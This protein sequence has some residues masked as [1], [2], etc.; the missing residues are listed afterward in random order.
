MLQKI[1]EDI[2]EFDGLIS[3]NTIERFIDEF[4]LPEHYSIKKMIN[5]GNG[6][7]YTGINLLIYKKS[8]LVG[9]VCVDSDKRITKTEY[10]D[11]GINIYKYTNICIVPTKDYREDDRNTLAKE[12]G[13]DY[14]NKLTVTQKI[15]LLQKYVDEHPFVVKPKQTK[16]KELKENDGRRKFNGV[17]G[18]AYVKHKEYVD[19][20]KHLPLNE[21]EAL[22]KEYISKNKNT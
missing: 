6:G 19:T 17:H 2:K 4:E 1:I 15:D 16:K 18:R 22:W 12:L 13:L 9:I 7:K 21:Y 5:Q 14:D 10:H 8:L 11:N 20:I 3:L